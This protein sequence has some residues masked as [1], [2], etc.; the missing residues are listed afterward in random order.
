MEFVNGKDDIPYIMEILWKIKNVP[1]HQPVNIKQQRFNIKQQRCGSHFC[2]LALTPM[3]SVSE[4]PSK[5]KRHG[6]APNA[7]YWLCI[8]VGSLRNGSYGW[9]MCR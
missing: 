6:A 9:K 5:G 3:Q 4:T 8:L 7:S 2:T 1:N